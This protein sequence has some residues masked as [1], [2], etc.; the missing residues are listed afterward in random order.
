MAALVRME[1]LKL[2]KRPMTWILIVLL[3]GGIGFGDVI[4]LLNLRSV[5]PEVRENI[6]VNLTLPGTL[7]R[8][9]QFIY[10]FGSIMLA[11][12]SAS[13]IGSEY[14]WGTLRPLLATGVPRGRFLGAKLL[15][16]ALV[17]LPFVVL[18]LVM[19]A[20][21][22]V[23]VA[24]LGDHA[25]F[26]GTLDA[27]WF[28]HLAALAGRTYLL[29]LMP[30]AL[31]FLIGLAGRSQAAGIGAAL[32]LMLGEQIVGA[33]LLSLGLDWARAV[34]DLF[35][36]QS[37]QTLLN[38]N[39]FGPVTAEPGMLSEGRALLTLGLYVVVGAVV[40]LLVFRRRDIRGTV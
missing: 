40:S 27:P 22:A 3:L 25:Y 6:L 36:I 14:S 31:A 23:P 16:L 20:I 33:V 18:P 8:A 11:I 39:T 9:T 4:G 28:G 32:G 2:V 1:L 29:V 15:A 35:P 7:T 26:V 19:N 37:S 13:A 17:A 10:I 34:V 38:H 30:M 5:T 21:L 12:L 24:L